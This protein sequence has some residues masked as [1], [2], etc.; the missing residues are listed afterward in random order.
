MIDLAK[1]NLG[2]VLQTRVGIEQDIAEGTLSFVPLRD[3]KLAQRKLM[4]LSRAE[5]EMSHAASA[6]GRMLGGLLDRL[7]DA[8]ND[9]T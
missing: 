1:R 4:L 3:T 2:T 6:L 7:R 5:K 9:S 8:T